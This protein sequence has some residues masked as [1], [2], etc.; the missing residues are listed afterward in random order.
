MR[1]TIYHFHGVISQSVALPDEPEPETL[2]AVSTGSPAIYL[3][4]ASAAPGHRRWR[5]VSPE[6]ALSRRAP[7]R[8]SKGP[9]EVLH[10]RVPPKIKAAL[11]AE[12]DK[13]HE[14]TSDTVTRIFAEYYSGSWRG[15]R[16]KR[17]GK[18][19]GKG[20]KS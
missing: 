10:V 16:D 13:L 6:K 9:A 20:A 4:P 5:K 18:R 2:Y 17:K 15:R 14:S 1:Y 19:K 7:G 3:I 8:P 11:D 12:A